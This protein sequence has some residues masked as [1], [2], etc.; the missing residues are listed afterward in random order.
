MNVSLLC[1]IELKVLGQRFIII[2]I[3]YVAIIIIINSKLTHKEFSGFN[4]QWVSLEC[5]LSIILTRIKLHYSPDNVPVSI[6]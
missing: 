2:G 6:H 5:G 3:S 4:W 1:S